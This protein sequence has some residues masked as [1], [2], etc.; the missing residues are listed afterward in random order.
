MGPFAYCWPADHVDCCVKQAFGWVE[1]IIKLSRIGTLSMQYVCVC[2]R[3]DDILLWP[4]RSPRFSAWRLLCD[5]LTDLIIYVHKYNTLY[6]EKSFREN[7]NDIF[8]HVCICQSLCNIQSFTH[9]VGIFERI[10][11]LTTRW[12]T[13]HESWP[14]PEISTP[15]SLG[16]YTGHA[17]WYLVSK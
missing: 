13:P 7:G 11:R 9:N 14:I 17:Q 2:Q 10:D 4:H 15:V 12:A 1:I 5:L 8:T 6:K 3:P 16:V